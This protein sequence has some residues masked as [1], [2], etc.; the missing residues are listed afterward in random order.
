MNTAGYDVAV[1]G[2]GVAG[3]L[4]ATLLADQGYTV[5]VLEP[6]LDPRPATGATGLRTLALTPAAR[7]VLEAAGAWSLLDHTRIGTFSRMTVW[8]AGSNGRIEFTPP[9]LMHDAMGYIVEQQNLV[10]ALAA[11]ARVRPALVLREHAFAAL[12]RGAPHRVTCADGSHVRARLVIGAD[13]AASHLR[14][15]LGIAVEQAPYQQSALLCNVRFAQA[16]GQVA[17]QRFLASGPLAALPLADP[18]ECAIVWSQDEARAQFL[19]ALDDAAFATTLAAEFAAVLGAAT[20]LGTRALFP[21]QRL[22]AERMVVDRC[23]VLGDAAHVVHPLAGQGLNLGMMDVAALVECLGT[24]ASAGPSWP[25]RAALR[26]FERWRG[27]ETAAMLMLTDRLHQ[28]FQLTAAPICAVRGFGLNLTDRSGP[29]KQWLIRRAM[30]DAG[31]V[32]RLAAAPPYP[33]AT[34]AARV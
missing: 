21:L 7:R 10:A 19:L 1:V 22:R 28:L 3:L 4:S 9:L 26:R 15:V 8:D 32:P 24:A 34:P 2:G 33:I 6:R 20:V 30:G 14:G 18:Y 16:H 5:C 13:G 11:S 12:E 29:L 23:V 31:E 17:R 25:P 27:C